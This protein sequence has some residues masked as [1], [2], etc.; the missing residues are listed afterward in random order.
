MEVCCRLIGVDRYHLKAQGRERAAGSQTTQGTRAKHKKTGVSRE[1]EKKLLWRNK[2][3]DCC[4]HHREEAN[5]D[6]YIAVKESTDN[7]SRFQHNEAG[8]YGDSVGIL[9]INDPCCKFECRKWHMTFSD[10]HI[11]QMVHFRSM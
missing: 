10:D 5:S 3:E 6:S 4:Q 7:I 9:S 11:M 8:K 1:V 2:G